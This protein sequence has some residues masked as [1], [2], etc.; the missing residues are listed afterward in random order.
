VPYASYLTPSQAK[1]IDIKIDD[2]S[3][4]TG[5][6]FSSTSPVGS[7]GKCINGTG[8]EDVTNANE[9]VLS[10]DNIACRTV[11]KLKK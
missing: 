4:V 7:T 8:G 6:M 11:F 9:Y 1:S 5:I 3:P 10:N 2:G